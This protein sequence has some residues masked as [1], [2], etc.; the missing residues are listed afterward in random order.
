MQ[1]SLYPN[2]K[3]QSL[4][5]SIHKCAVKLIGPNC[6]GVTQFMLLNSCLQSRVILCILCFPFS[7]VTLWR[8]TVSD[9]FS[10]LSMQVL[11]Q[12]Q[13]YCPVS[14]PLEPIRVFNSSGKHLLNSCLHR[15]GLS[16]PPTCSHGTLN[17]SSQRI[18]H[19]PLIVCLS[20]YL[21]AQIFKFRNYVWIT[22]VSPELS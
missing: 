22:F 6:L 19:C 5:E 14:H 20:I 10:A 4:E 13:S 21:S 15:S 11:V 17:F 2:H 18:P 9:P 3:I 16:V 12:V 7:P 1:L 8:S